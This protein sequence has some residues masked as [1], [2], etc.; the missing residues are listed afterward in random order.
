[1][2]TRPHISYAVVEA[3]KDNM[4]IVGL[5]FCNMCMELSIWAS[6]LLGVDLICMHSL[7]QI[8]RVIL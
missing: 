8:G 5:F 7:M 4:Y 2:N 3:N 1:M 6:V